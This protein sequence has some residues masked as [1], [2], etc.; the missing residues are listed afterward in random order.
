MSN[1]QIREDKLKICHVITRMIV[2]GA[3]ENT[4]LTAIGHVNNGHECVLVSGPSHGPEGELLRKIKIPNELKIVECPYL[5][6]EIHPFNDI[7]AYFWLKKFF[8][9][10]NFDVVHTHSSKAGIIAR[11]AA[12]KVNVPVIV[13]TIHGLAFHKF[14]NPLKNKI[15]I[16]AERWAA[17]RCHRILAVAQAMIEQSI[18]AK[19]AARDKFKLVYSGMELN[20]FLNNYGKREKMRKKLNIKNDVP[21]VGTLARLF[22]LKGYEDFLPVAAKIAKEIQNVEFIIIGDGLLKEKIKEESEKLGLKFHF[23]GLISPEQVP[24][25]IS[26]MDILIHLSMREGLPRAVV[27]ALASGIP[28]IAYDLDG[29]PEVIIN[30]RSGYIAKPRNVDEVANFAIK[31]LNNSSLR[32]KLGN[33]GRKIVKEKFDWINMV[34]TIEEEYKNIKYNKC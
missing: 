30:G 11:A 9:M 22:P 34:K 18:N 28:A 29:A 31:L 26:T 20:P 8:K 23:V 21:L 25:Y 5:C 4:L 1:F 2:G 33:E 13:H 10:K 15:Y 16:T 19:I 3:Q 14:E 17:K 7:S 27:Q 12:A 32:E 24:D 6:R